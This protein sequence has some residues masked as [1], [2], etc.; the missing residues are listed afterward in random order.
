MHV[1]DSVMWCKAFQPATHDCIEDQNTV[2]RIRSHSGYIFTGLKRPE[3]TVS[4]F[5]YSTP[6]HWHCT[7]V[8]S[9]VSEHTPYPVSRLYL[10]ASL[11]IN[12]FDVSRRANTN[13]F[14]PLRLPFPVPLWLLVYYALPAIR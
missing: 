1:H 10:G 5:P 4:G 13:I 14:K 11:L 8:V 12:D 6:F 3:L 2:E 7:N 9:I